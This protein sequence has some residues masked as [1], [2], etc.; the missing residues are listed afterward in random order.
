MFTVYDHLV[1]DV[2]GATSKFVLTMTSVEGAG[3]IPAAT[4]DALVAGERVT[5]RGA[6]LCTV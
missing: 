1:H 4:S 5:V 2:V 3:I 6:L